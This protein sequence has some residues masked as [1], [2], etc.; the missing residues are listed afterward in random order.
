MEVPDAQG[1]MTVVAPV[2][3]R[4]PERFPLGVVDL[5]EDAPARFDIR[6]PSVGERDETTMKAFVP[7]PRLELGQFS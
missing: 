5:L 6:A 1:E 7:Q 3:A 2:G 4:S